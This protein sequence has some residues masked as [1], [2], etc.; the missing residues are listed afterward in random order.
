[1]SIEVKYQIG[2][3]PK[4]HAPDT[5]VKTFESQEK[6]NEW[7]AKMQAWVNE[8]PDEPGDRVFSIL[9]TAYI[10]RTK[11]PEFHPSNHVQ[12]CDYHLGHYILG[13]QFPSDLRWKLPIEGCGA[14]ISHVIDSP[15]GPVTVWI[16][17]KRATLYRANEDG[18]KTYWRFDDGQFQA[19]SVSVQ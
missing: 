16:I 10:T 6:L 15:A 13:V 19:P 4:A 14:L 17:K 5:E 8:F 1:M 9:S 3:W 12:W 11:E 7:K 18:T 2:A